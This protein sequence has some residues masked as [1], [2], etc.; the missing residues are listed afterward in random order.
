[1]DKDKYL[2]L[3]SFRSL[4]VTSRFNLYRHTL[5]LSP[6]IIYITIFVLIIR[7]FNT[8]SLFNYY[9]VCSFKLK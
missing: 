2:L 1:M 4:T 3:A 6:F 9:Y 8:Q 5:Q 7:H